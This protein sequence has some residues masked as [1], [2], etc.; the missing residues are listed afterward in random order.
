[1][2]FH[3]YLGMMADG[4]LRLCAAAM[5]CLYL[6]FYFDLAFE[7]VSLLNTEGAVIK[8][9][10]G[11]PSLFPKFIHCIQLKTEYNIFLFQAPWHF[12]F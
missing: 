5:P 3:L 10:Q 7:Q 2:L 11:N 8:S 1:M 12:N 6:N 4:S 9:S